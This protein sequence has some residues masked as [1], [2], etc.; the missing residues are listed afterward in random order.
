MNNE[1]VKSWTVGEIVYLALADDCCGC[2]QES[3]G[4][5]Q[6]DQLQDAETGE[7]F[8]KA[9]AIEIIE[10]LSALLV[11]RKFRQTKTYSV[12]GNSYTIT[13]NKQEKT[14]EV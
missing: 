2:T 10:Y 11:H 14:N 4:G 5:C 13:K 1:M 9:E 8:V 6:P 3:C 12:L 7:V